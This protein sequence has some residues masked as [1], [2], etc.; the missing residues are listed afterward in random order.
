[1]N[2]RGRLLWTEKIRVRSGDMDEIGHVNNT[3]YVRYMEQARVAWL[4][5]LG[6]DPDPGRRAQCFNVMSPRVARSGY[7]C[8]RRLPGW[9]DGRSRCN[10]RR[11]RSSS[12]ASPV[13][14]A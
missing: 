5:S 11:D 7:R 9:Q 10:R 1:M 6:I 8:A 12:A 13:A 3:Y 14:A 2:E 4:Y